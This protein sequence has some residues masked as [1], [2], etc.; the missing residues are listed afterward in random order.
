MSLK[1]DESTNARL[2]LLLCGS[3]WGL[4]WPLI[5]IGLSGLSPWSMRLISFTV[6][7]TTLMIAVG[8]SGRS[9][10][11]RGAMTWVH[12]TVSSILNIVA[13]GV[14]TAFAILVT[15]TGRVAVVSYSFPVW[16]CL[17]A[18]PILGEKLRGT[19]ALALALCIGGLGV[20]I[21][22][23]IGTAGATGLALSVVAAVMWAAGTIYLKLIRIP[24]DPIANTAWQMVI[25]AL[26]MLVCHL[27]FQGLP[28]F[29]LAPAKAVV[30]TVVNGLVGSAFCY[31]LWYHIV[32]R[33]PATTAALGSLLS[34]AIGV[35]LSA[36]V[37]GEVPSTSDVIG[38][39]LIF[40]AAM[41]VILRRPAKVPA[42]DAATRQ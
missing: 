41:T 30:A 17:M 11:V 13:F 8:L 7:A 4:M 1:L 20:L 29:E 18:W 14:F 16:A 38:F 37:L 3:C 21:W 28:T 22:P 26:L 42:A 34:P 2:L 31:F 10:A 25:A 35:L 33:L 24:G 15:S 32:G 40:A 9:L 39:G 23:V 12:L 5:T 6:G 36:L 27:I 19:V